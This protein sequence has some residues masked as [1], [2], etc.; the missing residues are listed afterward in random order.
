[1]SARPLIS[2]INL[3]DPLTPSMTLF[4]NG[5]WSPDTFY[6]PPNTRNVF[7]ISVTPSMYL[8]GTSLT[9]FMSM[10]VRSGLETPLILFYEFGDT[11][12]TSPDAPY[13]TLRTSAAPPTPPIHLR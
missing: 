10:D 7:F 13:D 4:R 6:A 3:G 1:M 11:P 2:P 8:P 5:G 12:Y 9:L